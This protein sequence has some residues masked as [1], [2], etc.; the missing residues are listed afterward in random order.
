MEQTPS[1]PDEPEPSE[2][3]PE[4]GD[5]DVDPRVSEPIRTKQA[6]HEIKP[7][8]PEDVERARAVVEEVIEGHSE[9]PADDDTKG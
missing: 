3:D 6:G 4:D 9:E 8:S 2:A 5:S 1:D 7:A